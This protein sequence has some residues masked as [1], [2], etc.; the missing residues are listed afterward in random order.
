MF[1][2]P[3]G[4][5]WAAAAI[6][7]IALFATGWWLGGS[8]KQGEWD[9]ARVKDSEAVAVALKESHDQAIA[10][11]RELTQKLNSQSKQYQAKLQEKDREKAAAIER[12][13]IDG[14]RVDVQASSSKDGVS[15]AAPGSCRCD[16]GETARLSAEASERLISLLSEADQ[17]VEQ[18][19][20][21]QKILKE[22]RDDKQQK[23]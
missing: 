18:L 11:E 23:N 20:A 21:C 3:G 10:K 9:A 12:A 14:L 7:S 2:I 8:L 1:L 17:V 15:G 5:K 19:A 16:G 6:I 4:A 13:R 22:E